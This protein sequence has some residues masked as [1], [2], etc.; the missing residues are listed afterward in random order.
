MIDYMQKGGPLMWL[1][2]LCSVVAG[3]VFF[4]RAA[5]F[6]RAT[7]RV[8]EFM[9]GLTNL[10]QHR[11]WAEAQ[12]ECAATPSPVTRVIHAAILRHDAARV[13]LKEIVQETGQLEVPR[14]ERRLSVLATIGLVTPL[15]GFLGTI[16]GLIEAFVNISSQSGYASAT[17]ISGGI[18]QSL[19]T[20]AAGLVVAIPCFVA[21]SYLSSRVNALMHDME[22]AGIEIVN[23]INENRDS[24]A[25]IIEFGAVKRLTRGS[26]E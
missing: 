13:E 25:E 21:Y 10:V 24:A 2:L 15:I 9:R 23:L 5:Y 3:A 22:R 14:L 17:D 1:I 16:V 20:T 26:G 19:L 7:I 6:Y 12:M 11:R 8:G 4:E 18:Y